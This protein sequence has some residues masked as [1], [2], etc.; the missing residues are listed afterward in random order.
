ME[1]TSQKQL[2]LKLLPVFNVKKRLLSITKHKNITNENIW[3]YLAQTKWKHSNNLT[4]SEM[5]NDEIEKYIGGT[6]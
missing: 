3:L 4:I 1:F 2:Y 6:E 5:I